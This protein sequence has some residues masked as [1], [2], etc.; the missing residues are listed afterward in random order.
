MKQLLAGV[1][2]VVLLVV[3]IT[4]AF[5]T[6]NQSVA[7]KTNSQAAYMDAWGRAQAMIITAK[8]ESW[9]DF[10]TA[11]LPWAVLGI[12]VIFGTV[13]IIFLLKTNPP[14]QPKIER[15]TVYYVGTQP[16]EVE[17]ERN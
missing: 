4:L 8:G 11:S 6:Y 5:S 13:A 17:H 1:M 7:D 10:S 9:K 2:V 14:G 15:Q 12:S 3:A 16:A